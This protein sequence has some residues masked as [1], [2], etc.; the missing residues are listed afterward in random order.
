MWIRNACNDYW[1]EWPSNHAAEGARRQHASPPTRRGDPRLPSKLEC[2]RPVHGCEPG[3]EGPPTT[4]RRVPR[5]RGGRGQEERLWHCR[6]ALRGPK[7]RAPNDTAPKTSWVSEHHFVGV[8]MWPLRHHPPAC[9]S[10]S[11][12]TH[13]V[14][15]NTTARS[16]CRPVASSSATRLR[17]AVSSTRCAPT[18]V[19]TPIRR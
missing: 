11:R 13:H 7:A 19:P 17:L 5:A 2:W 8:C 1:C 4:Y 10:L 12:A 16:F 14:N 18:S 3:H 6:R 15:K 9:F